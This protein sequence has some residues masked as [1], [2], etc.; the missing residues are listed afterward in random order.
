MKR[1]IV[2]TGAAM[3]WLGAVSAVSA[4][5]RDSV[6]RGDRLDRDALRDDVRIDRLKVPQ[7][8]VYSQQPVQA[9]PATGANQGQ[10]IR[11]RPHTRAMPAGKSQRQVQSRQGQTKSP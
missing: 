10:V 5:P 7:H 1:W 6:D 9:A 3:A 8:P 2:T 11:R 4:E